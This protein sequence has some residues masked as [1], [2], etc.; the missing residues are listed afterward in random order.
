MTARLILVAALCVLTLAL[1]ACDGGG[2]TVVRTGTEHPMQPETPTESMEQKSESK[3]WT[4]YALSDFR[5]KTPLISLTSGALVK[6]FALG[7]VKLFGALKPA[8]VQSEGLDLRWDFSDLDLVVFSEA[9]RDGL[10]HKHL[11]Y[12]FVLKPDG[13]G[14]HYDFSM[15]DDGR[16]KPS[17]IFQC[18]RS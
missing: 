10:L 8:T 7:G 13:T 12:A 6:N 14:L 2:V 15:S 5:K 11:Q 1:A 9:A 17:Q 3:T 4:R 18:L 16:A